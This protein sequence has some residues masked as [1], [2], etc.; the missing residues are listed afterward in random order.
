MV[1]PDQADL[2]CNYSCM[3]C[4]YSFQ[5]PLDVYGIDASI[6]TQILKSPHTLLVHFAA[7]DNGR[8]PDI[9]TLKKDRGDIFS[10]FCAESFKANFIRYVN[11]VLF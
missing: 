1:H 4:R 8:K 5:L 9:G 6:D 11:E 2:N 3:T 7:L 10:E